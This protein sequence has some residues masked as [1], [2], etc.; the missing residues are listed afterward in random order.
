MENKLKKI[1]NN[2]M[3]IKKIFLVLFTFTLLFAQKAVLTPPATCAASGFCCNQQVTQDS[4][5]S[6]SYWEYNGTTCVKHIVTKQADDTYDYN[7]AAGASMANYQC[8]ST[9]SCTQ[10]GNT[11]LSLPSIGTR[12][13][14]ANWT[15]GAA[16]PT[17][18]GLYC[19][20]PQARWSETAGCTGGGL[21]STYTCTALQTCLDLN[22]GGQICQQKSGVAKDYPNQCCPYSDPDIQYNTQFQACAKSVP[23][24]ANLQ[25]SNPATLC[26]TGQL[27]VAANYIPDSTKTFYQCSDNYSSS[28]GCGNAADPSQRCVNTAFGIINANPSAFITQ[29]VRIGIGIGSGIALALIIYGSFKISTS[30]GVPEA[31]AEGKEIIT[32]AIIGLIFMI[33]S[34]TLMQILGV[35]ILGLG[36]FGLGISDNNSTGEQIF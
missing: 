12:V 14:Y 25:V 32:S 3:S 1:Y 26:Q 31:I 16:A 36:A 6:V 34:V 30:Q 9:E 5:T 27:C 23:G 24:Q 11:S 17:L 20:S 10:T 29:L 21:E 22:N 19:C 7:G 28:V 33:L 4:P 18:S 13:P 2:F 15:C 8:A 35:D